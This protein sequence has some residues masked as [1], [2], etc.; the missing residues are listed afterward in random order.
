MK[1]YE[2]NT[3]IEMLVAYAEA[4]AEQNDGVIP[5]HLQERMNEL[6]IVRDDKIEA[7]G[8]VIKEKIALAGALFEEEK[9]LQARRKQAEKTIDW[10]KSYLSSN[11][12]E[13]FETPWVAISF[14]KSSSVE[15]D[16]TKLEDSYCNIK[17]IRTP[18]KTYIKECINA[19][20]KVEGAWITERKN[21]V[22]K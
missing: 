14:R 15:V 18:D 16:E 22:I 4:F 2:I 21:V 1:L 11:L 5:D 12:S 13:K 6:Q 10:L 8:V 3:E 9:V 7:I 17:T 19:G 20:V